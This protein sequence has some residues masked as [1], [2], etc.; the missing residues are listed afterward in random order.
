MTDQ[1]R[2]R[3]PR[4]VSTPWSSVTLRSGHR[5]L[6]CDFA[7]VATGFECASCFVSWPLRHPRPSSFAPPSRSTTATGSGAR[8]TPGIVG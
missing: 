5:N 7:G 8:S 4:G 2:S 3:R 6:Q 1:V